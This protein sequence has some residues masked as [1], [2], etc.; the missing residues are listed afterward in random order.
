[1]DHEK[2][3]DIKLYEASSCISEIGAGINF[4]PRTWAILKAIGLEENLIRLLPQDP[5]DSPRK[6]ISNSFH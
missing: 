6:S 3:L 2:R 5:D 1:M 4:W